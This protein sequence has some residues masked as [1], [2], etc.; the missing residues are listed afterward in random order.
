M[1]IDVFQDGSYITTFYDVDDTARG[2][3][4]FL[5]R[6]CEGEGYTI[7]DDMSC[8]LREAAEEFLSDG[9]IDLCSYILKIS[10]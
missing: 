9:T 5:C 10:D 2:I 1:D 4:C 3:H 7:T 8:I 6:F